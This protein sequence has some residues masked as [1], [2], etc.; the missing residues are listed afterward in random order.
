MDVWDDESRVVVT[1]DMLPG[2]AVFAQHSVPIIIGKATYAFNGVWFFLIVRCDVVWGVLQ[3]L[4]RRLQVVIELELSVAWV[5]KV[6]SHN[7]ETL[8]MVL[9]LSDRLR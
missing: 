1:L 4:W 2:V 6:F 7:L 5:E 8:V 9:A 3:N